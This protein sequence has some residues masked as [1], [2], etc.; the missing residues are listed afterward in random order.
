MSSNLQSL[1]PDCDSGAQFALQ[2]PEMASVK[3]EDCSQTLELN[4]KIKDEEEEKIGKSVS[5]GDHVET[6]PA[7]RQQQQEDPRAK[8]SHPC[9]H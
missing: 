4:V 2:D 6:F 5:H 1:G 8:R 7:S 9:P 3:L